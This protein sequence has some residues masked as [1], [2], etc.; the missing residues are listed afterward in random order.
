MRGLNDGRRGHH[1]VNRA[2]STEPPARVSASTVLSVSSVERYASQC[3]GAPAGR[4]S[5]PCIPLTTRPRDAHDRTVHR[6]WELSPRPWRECGG[7]AP[8]GGGGRAAKGT[9]D[10]AARVTAAEV[11]QSPISGLASESEHHDKV[12]IGRCALK[13]N[14]SHYC[15][16]S[17][18]RIV[19]LLFIA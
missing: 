7:P 12:I 16:R 18:A 4:L 14:R 17:P 3:E 2:L 1:H 6:R 9:K 8:S 13:C 19:R 5:S 10:R 15:S 11:S